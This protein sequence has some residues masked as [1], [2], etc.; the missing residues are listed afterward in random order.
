M[1][2]GR[3][4][5]IPPSVDGHLGC[6]HLS[7][8]SINYAIMSMGVQIFVQVPPFTS[9]E[10]VSRSGIAG[11]YGSSIL[12]FWRK[13]QIIFHTDCSTSDSH[14]ECTRVSI[15]YLLANA[16]YLFS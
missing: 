9:F 4:L 6:F 15:S 7:A 8:L 11:S 3:V 2:I 1:C 14:L 12:S 10:C 5:F 16:R 13:L